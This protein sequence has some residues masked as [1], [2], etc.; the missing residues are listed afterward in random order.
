MRSLSAAVN[1]RRRGRAENSALAAS[2]AGTT[3]GRR[4]PLAPAPDAAFISLES[5]GMTEMIL[6]RPQG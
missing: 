2:G 5:M 6:P 3:V 4:P 1:V